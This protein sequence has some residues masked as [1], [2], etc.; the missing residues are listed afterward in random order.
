MLL[1]CHGVALLPGWETS[2]GARREVQMADDLQMPVRPVQAWC[3]SFSCDQKNDADR[4]E[5][6]IK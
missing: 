2:R 3:A 5:E 6:P 1:A 4:T